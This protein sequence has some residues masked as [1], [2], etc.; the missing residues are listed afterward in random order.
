MKM[1]LMYADAA[2]MDLVRGDLEALGATHYT[3]LPVA[4]GHGR[5]GW[6]DGTRVHPGALALVMV[7]E[8]DARA[9]GLFDDLVARRDARGDEAYKLFLMPVD[10]Q[11]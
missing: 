5:S 11:A 7:I 3:V 1:V 2:R 6:H 10:R 4:E 9:A 8:E